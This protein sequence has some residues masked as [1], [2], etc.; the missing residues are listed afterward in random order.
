MD[1]YLTYCNQDKYYFLFFLG[2]HLARNSTRYC[3]KARG[4][5]IYENIESQ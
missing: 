3:F 2:L 1:L 5:D 4:S